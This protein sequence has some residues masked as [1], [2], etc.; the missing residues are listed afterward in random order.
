MIYIVY[1]RSLNRY[2]ASSSYFSRYNMTAKELKKFLSEFFE[3]S[4]LDY[5]INQIPARIQS[6]SDFLCELIYK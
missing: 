3:C 6:I 2:S 1:Y 5:S 4:F